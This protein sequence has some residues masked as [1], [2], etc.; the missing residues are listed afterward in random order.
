MGWLQQQSKGCG[1]QMGNA[2]QGKWGML[3]SSAVG[4]PKASGSDNCSKSSNKNYY[5]ALL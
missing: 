5:A 1:G 3:L 2:A 4:C